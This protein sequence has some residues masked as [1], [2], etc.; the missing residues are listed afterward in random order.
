MNAD[1]VTISAGDVEMAYERIGPIEAA[2]G[3]L[4][5]FS[6]SPTIE[7]VNTK[8]RVVAHGLGAN[9]VVH[10]EYARGTKLWSW[11]ALTAKGTAVIAQRGSQ[12]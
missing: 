12:S 2:S 9:A 4:S 6:K 8:L 3:A 7:H 11:S 5:I 1:Q 10:V